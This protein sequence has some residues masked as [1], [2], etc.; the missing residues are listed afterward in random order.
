M[1]G[2]LLLAALGS[3]F[4]VRRLSLEGG[5]HDPQAHRMWASVV[6]VSECSIAALQHG[7]LLL[8]E[9]VKSR[10]PHAGRHLFFSMK[11]RFFKSLDYQ[12]RSRNYLFF[13]N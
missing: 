11:G 12:G 2:F 8:L 3:F 7:I 1:A 10:V 4:V 9:I 5:P 6:V 13:Y